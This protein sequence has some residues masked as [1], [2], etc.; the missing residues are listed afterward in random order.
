MQR[1]EDIIMQINAGLPSDSDIDQIMDAEMASMQDLEG[2]SD[3][4]NVS[5]ESDAGEQVERKDV[6]DDITTGEVCCPNGSARF[7][8]GY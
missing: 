3:D 1:G 2:V 8:T 5:D 6:Q 7:N 4:E